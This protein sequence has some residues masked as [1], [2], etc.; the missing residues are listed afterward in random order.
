MLEATA[1][2]GDVTP[3][4]CA[5]TGAWAA[6]RRLSR[7]RL[8]TACEAGSPPRADS[9]APTGVAWHGDVCPLS[10]LVAH[11]TGRER[12]PEARCIWRGEQ[13]VHAGRNSRTEFVQAVT[14]RHACHAPSARCEM[15]TR[16]GYDIATGGHQDGLQLAVL[17]MPAAGMPAA[18]SSLHCRVAALQA[19]LRSDGP[20]LVVHVLVRVLLH[21][22]RRAL[23]VQE[24]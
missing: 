22:E 6:V 1:R 7:R 16:C 23:H 14:A 19:R 12:Q 13:C 20:D 5:H 24:Q 10:W 17:G 2:E 4:V 11:T 9:R 21:H 15:H 3:T 18:A 8:V